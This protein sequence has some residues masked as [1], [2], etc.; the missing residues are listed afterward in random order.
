MKKV[1][2]TV[3]TTYLVKLTVDVED[4]VYETLEETEEFS[5]EEVLSDE[6]NE[7]F[8]FLSQNITEE[9]AMSTCYEVFEVLVKDE[10]TNKQT[11]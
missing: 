3:K 9:Y 6:D 11:N 1:E 10:K 8:E 5:D 2:L 4:S 7:V